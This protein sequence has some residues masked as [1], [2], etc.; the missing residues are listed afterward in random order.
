MTD[1]SVTHST[2]VIERV[3]PAAPARVFAALANP[4]RKRRWFAEG[5]GFKLDSFDMDFRV[6]GFERSRFRFAG[7]QPLPEGTACGNDTVF[8][9]IVADQRIVLAYTMTVGGKPISV[10]QATFELQASGTGTNLVFTEQAAF[11]EGSDGPQIR[12]AGW[13]SLF[14]QL[15]EEVAESTQNGPPR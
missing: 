5:E 2:F 11:F 1:R 14:E 12:E 15:A 6:G 8:M 3:F 4:A 10:S 7:S 13:H 9:D